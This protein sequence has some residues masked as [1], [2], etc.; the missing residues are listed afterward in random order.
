V[1]GLLVGRVTRQDLKI[2]IFTETY[3]PEIGGGETQSRLL[4]EGLIAHGHA[5]RVLTRWSSPATDQSEKEGVVLVDR[6]PPIGPGQ[7]KKWGLIL[8]SI[9]WLVGQRREYDLIFVSGFRIVGITAVLAGKLLGKGCVLKADSQGEM[10]GDFFRA[11]LRRI[12]RAPGWPVFKFFLRVRNGILRRSDAFAAISDEIAAEFVAQGVPSHKIHLIPNG[13]DTELFSPAEPAIKTRLR[14]KLELPQDA[15]I[16]I[17]SG[18]LVSYK[19]L[20]RLLEVWREVHRK[21]PQTRLILVGAGGLD[22]HNC[23]ADLRAYVSAH[24][25]GPW[26]KFTGSIRN[27]YEY[28]QAADLFVFPTENDAFPSSLI[29]AMACALPVVSTP[30][31]A[32]PRI[33][34]HEQNGLLVEPGR[35]QQLV[36]ALDRLFSDPGLASRLG[37]AARKTVEDRYSASSVTRAYLALFKAAVDASRRRPL[38]SIQ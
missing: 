14:E 1:L 24:Q 11:G 5:A 36:Q 7:L 19:G 2:C 37:L 25:L 13:V 18:R 23:E 32:I 17:Y 15:T 30:V 35:A 28:L 6:L 31:G 8:T 3:H 29:E 21:H 4:A 38:G 9:V 26:V 12:G 22:I 33:I 27:V 34:T 10:S 20:P 16:A